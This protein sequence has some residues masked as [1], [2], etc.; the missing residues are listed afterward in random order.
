MSDDPPA[1]LETGQTIPAFTTVDQDGNEV[2][3]TALTKR[4]VFY[5]YPKDDTPGCTIQACD[6]R[7]AWGRLGATGI[8]VYGVSKDSKASHDRFIAK[9]DL[10]FPLI[11]DEDLALNTAFGV[12]QEKRNYGKSYMGTVRST[13][14]ADPDGTLVWVGYN[15]QAKGHVER[16]LNDLGVA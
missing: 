3:S 10:P 16:L 13:F 4:T 5:F 11:V 6:F 7:D 15:V 12:W 8:D 9:F 14:V 1:T 2:S